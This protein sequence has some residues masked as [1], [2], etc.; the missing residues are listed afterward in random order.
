MDT[1]RKALAMLLAAIIAVAVGA[2]IYVL[3]TDESSLTIVKT[4]E[5]ILKV[6][7]PSIGP[8][9]PATGYYL[10]FEGNTSKIFVVSVNIRASSY[11]YD[12]YQT[13]EYQLPNGTLGGGWI[14]RHDEPCVVINVT[15]RN[16]YSAQNP[17]P[18][19]W[20]G[21]NGTYVYM[22]AGLFSGNNVVNSTD[23]IEIGFPPPSASDVWLNF[24]DTGALSIY[25]GVYS[26]EEITGFQLQT[27]EISAEPAI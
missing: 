25:L 1:R 11:P 13:D 27:L 16:D 17:S 20:Y 19:D 24:G 15:L 22:T 21:F 18:N 8:I 6:V 3:R 14:V 26:H 5:S 9:Q 10:P 4:D 2:T 12:T 7:K 23:L